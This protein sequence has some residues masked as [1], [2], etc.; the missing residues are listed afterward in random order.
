MAE[1]QIVRTVQN[2]QAGN[3][4][5]QKEAV[6]RN[7]KVTIGDT[8]EFTLAKF[9]QIFWFIGHFIMALLT[10]RFVFLALGANLT[11][12]V[13]FIYN[14][15]SVFVLPFRGIFPSPRAGEFFFDSAALLGIGMYY[16]I[17]FLLIGIIRLFSKRTPETI[18]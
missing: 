6:V 5:V 12:I 11:G 13:L 7:D 17:I 8:H 15:S 1:T 14:L 9:E 4:A 10:L 3:T 2:Q 18:E 16:L